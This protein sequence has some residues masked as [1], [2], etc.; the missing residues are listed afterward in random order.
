MYKKVCRHEVLKAYSV[1]FNACKSVRKY[2]GIPDDEFVGMAIAVGYVDKNAEVNDP[3]YIPFV[4][5]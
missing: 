3:V 5:L 2:N 1:I 4:I